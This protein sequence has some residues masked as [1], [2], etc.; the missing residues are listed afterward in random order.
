MRAWEEEA[1]VMKRIEAFRK[2]VLKVTAP[3]ARDVVLTG[4][5]SGWAPGMVRLAKA[6]GDAWSGT[7][8]LAPGEYQYR[9]IVDGQWRDHAEAERRVPNPFGGE[10]C[11]LV[12]R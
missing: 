1:M 10:N 7:L 4:D 9:L 6:A 5:F 12:V 8:E 11:V 3:G 2:I